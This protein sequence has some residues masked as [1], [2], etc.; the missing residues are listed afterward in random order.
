MTI[1][2]KFFSL[3]RNDS[4]WLKLNVNFDNYNK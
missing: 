3:V 1:E 2:I 4:V